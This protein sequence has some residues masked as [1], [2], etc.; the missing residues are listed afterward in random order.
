MI[1]TESERRKRHPLST[2]W[3]ITHSGDGGPE[4]ITNGC[5]SDKTLPVFGFEEEAE[6]FLK[7]ASLEDGL[8]IRRATTGELLSVLLGP[9]KDTGWVSFDPLPG[10]FAEPK[11]DPSRMERGRF[12]AF[13]TG[14][15]GIRAT[16]EV[17]VLRG[18]S[19]PASG[20]WRVRVRVPQT[21]NSRF[22]D[23]ANEVA[24]FRDFGES[25][26]SGSE[27]RREEIL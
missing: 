15:A 26:G 22:T 21:R 10:A 12:M 19:I 24:T 1:R 20:T 6:M 5:G 2:Y 23:S 8:R 4:P 25:D 17:E 27:A 13:L 3:L 16:V 7:F 14:E 9:C 18:S 11:S